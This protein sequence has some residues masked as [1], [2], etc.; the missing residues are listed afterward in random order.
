MTDM[1]TREQ[2][3]LEMLQALGTDRLFVHVALDR[4]KVD[5]RY[6]RAL[7]MVRVRKMAANFDEK[8]VGVL[9]CSVR[10]DGVYV[11]DGQHRLEV[12]RLLGRETVQCELRTGLTLE[13]EAKM[14]YHLDSDR[15]GLSGEAAFR[16]LL[17]AQDPLALAIEQ[18]VKDAGLTI[19][20]SGPHAG[21]VRAFKTMLNLA[22][23]KGLASL[24][25]ALR[26]MGMA[27]PTSVH[28]APAILLEGMILFQQ[29]YP[30][31]SERDLGRVLGTVTDPEKLTLQGRTL[32]ENLSWG[33]AGAMARAIL[34]NYNYHRSV[35]RLED[36]FPTDGR[37]VTIRKRNIRSK[38]KEGDT[39]VQ[40]S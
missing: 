39:N 14:F 35:N 38:S 34:G 2:S 8:L 32:A 37:S 5:P 24:A 9:T 36:R 29:T 25:A 18:A 10:A 15:Q 13:D 40:A 19:A 1:E 28:V 22:R 11:I 20:Y 33:S 16:A 21:G 23:D 27:W 17:T 7:N 30:E 3:F 26:V 31:I 6:Q 12:L 4:I